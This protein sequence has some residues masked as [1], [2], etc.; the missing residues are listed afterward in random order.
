MLEVISV[1]SLE[2]KNGL[3]QTTKTLKILWNLNHQTIQ[4]FLCEKFRK[5]I[6][7]QKDSQFKI[8]T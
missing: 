7:F 1:H 3:E 6:Y 4:V 5:T 2:R 8:R